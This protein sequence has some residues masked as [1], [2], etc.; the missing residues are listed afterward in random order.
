MSSDKASGSDRV[1]DVAVIG[2]G[3]N[4]AGI[5]ADASRR[6]YSVVLFEADD[7]AGATSSASSKLIHG[8]L[9]YL[10]HY[11][12]RLVRESLREREILLAKAPHI[13]WPLRFV[14]PYVDGMRPAW[15]L[16]S[17]L[18]IYDHL[19][20]RQ[21]IPASRGLNLNRSSAGH[22]LNREITLG[23]SYWDCWVDDARLV[24]ANAQAAAAAGASIRTRTRVRSA[25]RADGVWEIGA[26]RGDKD[27]AFRAR[28]LVNAGGPWAGDIAGLIGDGEESGGGGGGGGGAAATK[29]R[30]VKGSHIVVPRVEGADDAFIFQN[31]DGRVVFALPFEGAFT[32]IGTTDVPFS[33]D[34]RHVAPSEEEE[35][36]LLDVAN[37]FFREPLSQADIVWRFAGV[38]PLQ[39]DGSDTAQT[40]SRDYVLHF[41]TSPGPP[42]VNVIGGKITPYRRLAENLVDVLSETLPE[43]RG[44]LPAK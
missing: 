32:L 25:V 15:M 16:R 3:I 33:G 7:L 29:L 31:N 12:F 23:F 21:A 37:R 27:E 17:G 1:F 40:V 11:A 43:R 4:G 20:H 38:R 5:A 26:T 19:T 8:G 42:L 41:D 13:I 36:Y 35:R 2:G 14:L 28:S 44:P 34:P 18:F 39:D 9:R 10:E 30:L 22:A 24:V 6:G